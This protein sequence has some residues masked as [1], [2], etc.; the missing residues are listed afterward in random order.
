MKTFIVVW[1]GVGWCWRVEERPWVAGVEVAVRCA[2]LCCCSLACIYTHYP[3]APVEQ[4]PEA[5][6]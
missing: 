2:W 4:S 1:G 5:W 3:V 6:R